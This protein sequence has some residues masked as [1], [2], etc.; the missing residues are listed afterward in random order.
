MGSFVV[1]FLLDWDADWTSCGGPTVEEYGNSEYTHPT[2]IG[3]GR[4]AQGPE[5][6]LL[7]APLLFPAF[8]LQLA[9]TFNSH[10]RLCVCYHVCEKV[11]FGIYV[12]GEALASFSFKIPFI[13]ALF[14]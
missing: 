12:F 9:E 14:F 2:T 8:A 1:F 13:F 3:L 11:L 10:D 6:K 4:C 5:G 7:T